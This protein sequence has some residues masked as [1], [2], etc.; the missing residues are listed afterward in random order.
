MALLLIAVGYESLVVVPGARNEVAELQAPQVLPSASLM[1]A[2]SDR[3]PGVSAKPNQPF[4]LFV[5]IPADSQFSS[6]SCDL[7]SP[8]GALLWSLPISADAARN[9]LPLKIP[10]GSA[11]SGRYSL[12]VSGIDANHHSTVLVRYPFELQV[13]R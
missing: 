6:Y 5:D 8:S 9:T 3:I 12:A 7:Y 11:D 10:A 13:Q 2:R 1:S 4:L